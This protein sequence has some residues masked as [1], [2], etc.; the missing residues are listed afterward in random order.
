VKS[1]LKIAAI[2]NQNNNHYSLVRYLRDEGYDADL[3]LTNAEQDHFHPSCDAYDLSYSSFTKQLCWGSV[4]SFLKTPKKQVVD[5]LKSYD[6]LIGTGL[7]PAYASRSGIRL[8]VF[9]PYGNDIERLLA[10]KIVPPHYIHHDF[11][12]VYHQRRGISQSRVIHAGKMNSVYESNL[13]KYANTSDRWYEFMPMVYTPQYEILKNEDN[14]PN[15][16]WRNEFISIRKRFS[17]MIFFG[18][19][20]NFFSNVDDGNTKGVDIFINGYSTFLR[21]NPSCNA[22]A[23]FT[24][25]GTDVERAKKLA[26]NLGIKDRCIWLPKMYRKDLMVGL[27]FV[28]VC[29][30]QFGIS[31][32]SNG[33]IFEALAS[34]KPLLTWRDPEQ[35]GDQEGLYPIYNANTPEEIAS[36]IE[37]YLANRTQGTEI[38]L[39]GQLWY[40]ERNVKKTLERYCNFF[41]KR[42]LELGKSSGK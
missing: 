20:N 40:Q 12:S 29:C 25:Y 36:S 4:R 18:A 19:R 41:D 3:L 17:L 22:V 39:E 33:T 30:G 15:T 35:Y 16:H 37:K 2:G 1:K 6:I 38:G 32:I 10:Y 34:A 13:R 28:D 31:W 42:A 14:L 11:F 9:D 8:D 5:D 24:D 7:V 21:N 26:C 27:S 23:V